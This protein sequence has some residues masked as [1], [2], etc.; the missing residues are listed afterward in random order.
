MAVVDW[1]RD[2]YLLDLPSSARGQAD[3]AARAR[4]LFPASDGLVVVGAWV[5][6]SGLARVVADAVA[7]ADRV[8]SGVLWGGAA[9]G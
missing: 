2:S 1:A 7:E 9:T 3:D 8:R 5:A 6:G 4:D